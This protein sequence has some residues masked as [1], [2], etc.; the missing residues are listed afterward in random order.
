MIVPSTMTPE[1]RLIL[2][3]GFAGSGKSTTAQRLWI[4]LRNN[5][6]EAVWFHEHEP[7]HPIFHFSE[8][9]ELP[10]LRCE[11]FLEQIVT[12]WEVLAQNGDDGPIRILEGSLIQLPVGVM[13]SQ[14]VSTRRIRAIVLKIASLVKRL[15]PAVIYLH[16]ADSRA[17]FLR[18]AQNRG[19]QWINRMTELLFQTPYG[20]LHSKDRT[21]RDSS[22]LIE[23][24]REQQI[25]V[26]SVFPE[27]QLRKITIDLNL[28]QWEASYRKMAA[29][30]KMGRLKLLTLTQ[31]QLL[32]YVGKFRGETTGNECRITADEKFLYIHLP[33]ADTAIRLLPVCFMTGEFCLQALAI[34]I[35]FEYHGADMLLRFTCDIRV[36]DR[37]FDDVV[38]S[39]VPAQGC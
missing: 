37:R 13:L 33:S 28:H 5:G 10:R 25:I 32:R 31:S 2:V 15:N 21:V 30:L 18:N 22:L 17:W 34:G 20:K 35:H 36:A 16:G 1:M 3:D 26:E 8:V 24:Y 9:D 6:Y 4:H 19:E 23:F 7:T 38:W 29:L 14:N 12:N 27:L 39:R 11:S